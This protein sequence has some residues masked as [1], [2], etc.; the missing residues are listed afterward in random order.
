MAARAGSLLLGFE[1]R[2]NKC[3][4]FCEFLINPDVDVEIECIA[5]K[6]TNRA[7]QRYVC[8]TEMLSIFRIRIGNI[9]PSAT[10]W[11]KR[12]LP[13]GLRWPPFNTVGP[14]QTPP[15]TAAPT[16]EA[17]SHTYA[18]KSSL[19]TM[20]RPKFAPKVPLP[21]D[22]L[23]NPSTCVIC[24]PVRSMVPNGIRIRS[25]VFPQCTG[26]TDRRTDRRTDRPTDRSRE[27]LMTIGRSAQRATQ[28]NN[29]LLGAFCDVI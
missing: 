28:P 27:S 17:L 29:T 4:F 15:Q 13:V 11:P 3:F 2:Q 21:V 20:A 7:F 23:P 1:C 14:T 12:P 22:R 5:K 9:S 6:R 16:V 26:Q 24:G 8:R 25:A 19:V 10:Q 18:V